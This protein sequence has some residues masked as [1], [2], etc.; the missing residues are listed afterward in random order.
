MASKQYTADELRKRRN[1]Q[2]Y[3]SRFR[4]G[5]ASICPLWGGYTVSKSGYHPS[6]AKKAGIK[7]KEPAK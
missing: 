5:Y 7:W 4:C 6:C 2:W 1:R 3:E